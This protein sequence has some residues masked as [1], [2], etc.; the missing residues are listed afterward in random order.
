MHP[1][2]AG[3]ITV[4]PCDVASPLSSNVNYSVSQVVPNSVISPVSTDG[5]VCIYSQSPSD[6]IIDLVGWLPTATPTSFMG[7]TP[8]RLVDTRDGTGGQLY[9]L[10]P[11]GQLS[12]AVHA[13]PISVAGT[14]VTI[15][16]TAAAL[17]VTIVNPEAAGFATVWPCS[18]ERPL[19]SNLN[20]AAGDTVANNVIAPI[21]SH[22]EI[23]FYTNAASD[24]IVD[25]AG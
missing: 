8:T 18:A 17:N 7:V 20:F 24:I 9:T 3:F 5:T 12:V 23:C 2:A 16:T 14:T 25:I 13:A 21:D 22:G 15:P 11:L 1:E 10:S 4:H 6:I 19:A